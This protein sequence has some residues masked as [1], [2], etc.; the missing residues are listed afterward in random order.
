M[1]AIFPG[2][3]IDAGCR[4]S[5]GS[6]C[7]GIRAALNYPDVKRVEIRDKKLERILLDEPMAI[8]SGCNSGFQALNLA[9]QFGVKGV[10]FIGLDRTDKNGLHFYGRNNWDGA[11]NPQ[12]ENFQTW[13][14]GFANAGAFFL[15]RGVD[16]V[17]CSSETAVTAFRKD[18][19]KKTLN[20]WGIDRGGDQGVA[21]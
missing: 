4:N 12:R 7:P 6:S 5:K 1:A 3:V 19:I 17:N 11:N 9:A 15:S 21:P 18:T 16:I 14:R 20:V 13:Q 2:G 10:M 8:G